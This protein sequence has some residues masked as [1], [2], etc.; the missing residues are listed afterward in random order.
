MAIDCNGSRLTVHR[1]GHPQGTAHLSTA[2]VSAQPY[3]VSLYLHLPRTSS[4]IAAGNFMLDVTLLAPTAKSPATFS[5]LEYAAASL[6]STV[7]ARSRRPAILTYVSPLVDAASTLSGIP[8]YVLG[9]KTE[10]E[11]LTIPVFESVEFTKG[12]MN[13]PRFVRVAVEAD[14]KMQFYEV[15]VKI[16]ARF[17]GL[18]WIIY[19]HRILSYLFFTSTFWT[20]SMFSSLLAWFVLGSYFS[21]EQEG[22]VKKEKGKHEGD[23][24]KAEEEE[25][26]QFDPFST[27]DLS[28]TSRSFPTLG[29]QMPLHFSSRRDSGRRGQGEEEEDGIKREEDNIMA[30]TS[31]QPLGAEADDEDDDDEFGMRPWRD[32]GI[33]TSIDETDRRSNLNV[34]RRQRSLLGGDK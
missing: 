31:I 28:D 19:N 33:G 5:N 12:W 13:V 1:N 22:D 18:R 6:N 21:G 14:E 2:L 30:S 20:C 7:L 8:F 24:V 15:G 9:W 17:G 25:D 26:D 11:V 27:E 32:S 29:R 10:S 4:N 16:V 23:V 3:D 34:Q